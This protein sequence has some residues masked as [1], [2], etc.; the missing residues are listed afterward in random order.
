MKEEAKK[1]H[2]ND[3]LLSYLWL[4]IV[5]C[6][7]TDLVKSKD[8][9]ENGR[10]L[11]VRQDIE[12]K[13]LAL[14]QTYTENESAILNRV[15]LISKLT[16][17]NDI[18]KLFWKN[19]NSWK[20]LQFDSNYWHHSLED[21]LD[22][23][24]SE[25]KKNNLDGWT[26]LKSSVAE[27]I[28]EYCHKRTSNALFE[29]SIFVIMEVVSKNR[30]VLEEEILNIEDFFNG[31]LSKYKDVYTNISSFYH[32]LRNKA[33]SPIAIY[34][35][36]Y[37][38]FVKQK[39]KFFAPYRQS[40]IGIRNA[41]RESYVKIVNKEPSVLKKG[42][43]ILAKIIIEGPT[44]KVDS[45]ERKTS[46]SL[47]DTEKMVCDFGEYRFYFHTLTD[48]ILIQSEGYQ[49]IKFSS[50]MRLLMRFFIARVEMIVALLIIATQV[51]KGGME[52]M[53][54]LGIIFFGILIE[55]HLGNA[56]FW[57]VIYFIY[58][59]KTTISYQLESSLTILDSK[60][61]IYKLLYMLTGSNNYFMDSLISLAVFGLIQVLKSRGFQENYMV[62]FEDV[63]TA[64]IRVTLTY[65]SFALTRKCI[66]SLP[67]GTILRSSTSTIE[68][69]SST[70][71]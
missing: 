8:Y 49:K 2:L 26:R 32:Y 27:F 45:A 12:K 48:K 54:I 41:R 21:S 50:L 43:N 22:L 38:T 64:I 15:N 44:Y 42:A 70:N 9:K 52:N 16:E 39:D 19:I 28:Y 1:A 37:N 23:K 60:S 34:K 6:L 29:D 4:I 69:T 58:L 35:Q 66:R 25:L 63:G 17:L 51:Y 20:K 24:I 36:K 65:H 5:N 30:T 55:T 71:K 67:L 57:T 68:S 40:K 11:A 53:V 33:A 62:T 10:M 13:F 18:E 7:L 31:D 59:V 61:L 14:Y 46:Q 56:R 47:L 3:N